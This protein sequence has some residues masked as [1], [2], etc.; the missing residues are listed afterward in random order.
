MRPLVPLLL[1]SACLALAGCAAPTL[2]GETSAAAA[3]PASDGARAADDPGWP[4]PADAPVRPGVKAGSGDALLVGHFCTVNFVFGTPDNRTLYV[5][6]ASHCLTGKKLGDDVPLA[7]GAVHAVLA[8]CSYGAIDGTEECTDNTKDDD[9]RDWNDFA[10]LRIKDEDRAKV[11]PGLLRFGG[12]TGLAGALGPGDRVLTYGNTD[13]RDGGRP[14]PDALDARPGV[15][16]GRTDWITEVVL[17]GP[18][19][20]GDS[21]S[22]VLAADGS[23]LGVMKYL[24][25]GTNGVTNLDAALAY[26]H[27]NTP[28]RVELKTWPLDGPLPAAGR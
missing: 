2:P 3:D 9:E 13:L 15:V 25:A 27:E 16:T 14:L 28:L 18:G 12:P 23:A 7:S 26:L 22:P 1:A 24:G 4:D 19:I 11:H 8:Y 5:G 17:A 10:L 21:G 20:P 6:L